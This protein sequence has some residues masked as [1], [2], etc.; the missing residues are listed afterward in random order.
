MIEFKYTLDEA[1][2]D[3][4]EVTV[5]TWEITLEELVPVFERFLLACG[6]ILPPDCHIG[7]EYEE[8]SSMVAI[9]APVDHLV[10]KVTGANY[11]HD[12]VLEVTDCDDNPGTA[13]VDNGVTIASKLHKTQLSGE[14]MHTIAHDGQ[15]HTQA[16]PVGGGVNRITPEQVV[17]A[18]QIVG[19]Q[20]LQPWS[21][22]TVL[23]AAVRL[24]ALGGSC[25]DAPLARDIARAVEGME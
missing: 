2:P 13:E 24:F 5:T 16:M 20:Y 1:Y 15:M 12:N 10:D 9:S 21:V 6:Y 18:L 25:W 7:Y 22:S 23:A 14:E 8:D 4:T 11:W 17:E 3:R 19:T